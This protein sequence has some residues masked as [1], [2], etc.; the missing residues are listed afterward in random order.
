MQLHGWR[1]VCSFL[2]IIYFN[3]I[4]Y[5]GWNECPPHFRF[6]GEASPA[7]WGL[8][9]GSPPS[10]G[11][12]LLSRSSGDRQI[13]FIP[14][15]LHRKFAVPHCKPIYIK[16]SL[17]IFSEA[18]R[19]KR[20]LTGAGTGGLLTEPPG[21]RQQQRAQLRQARE[22]SSRWAQRWLF[23]PRLPSPPD[24]TTVLPH[25]V[26]AVS[27]PPG[28]PQHALHRVITGVLTQAPQL[29]RRAH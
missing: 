10:D 19:I 20:C 5:L 6:C 15:W 7:L 2:I 27:H 8:S 9:P 26:K 22:S 24:L 16:R 29:A 12:E 1:G 28:R 21:M 18:S 4:D 25:Q 11:V 14:R 23:L 3:G 13:L 17:E